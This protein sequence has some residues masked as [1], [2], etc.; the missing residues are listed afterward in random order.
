MVDKLP[1]IRPPKPVRKRSDILLAA[2]RTAFEAG[3]MAALKLKDDPTPWLGPKGAK[4]V[5]AGLSAAC[6]D[7][8]MERKHPQRKGGLAHTALRQATNFA[9]GG[10]VVKPVEKGKVKIPQPPPMRR[11]RAR[12]EGTEGGGRERS[13][14]SSDGGGERRRR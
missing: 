9:I 3:A 4:V 7:T 1:H 8:F 6:V 10:L 2:G 5:A 13:R 11:R 14:G 12:K